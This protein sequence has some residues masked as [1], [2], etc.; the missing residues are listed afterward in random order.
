VT[1]WVSKAEVAQLTGWSSR[2]IERLGSDDRIESRQAKATLRNGRAHREYAVHSLPGEAQRKYF[3]LSLARAA[4]QHALPDGER[5]RS[6]SGNPITS[7][8]FNG[9]ALQSGQPSEHCSDFQR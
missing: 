4:A 8:K 7:G 6:G 1:L 3:E 2:H 9:T 5:G